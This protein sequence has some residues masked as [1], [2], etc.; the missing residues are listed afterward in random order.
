MNWR[1]VDTVSSPAALI[2]KQWPE[3]ALAVADSVTGSITDLLK[4]AAPAR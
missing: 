3:I 2:D 4:R 1:R